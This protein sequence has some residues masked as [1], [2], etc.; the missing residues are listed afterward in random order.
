MLRVYALVLLL[1]VKE[2]FQGIF[3]LGDIW[4]VGMFTVLCNSDNRIASWWEINSD[5][6]YIIFDEGVI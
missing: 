1:E 3:L 6:K 4:H 5:F 2:R